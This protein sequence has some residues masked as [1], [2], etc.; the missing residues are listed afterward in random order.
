MIKKFY[1]STFILVFLLSTTGLPLTLHLCAMQKSATLET[2]E[3]C[4]A[5]P[6]KVKTC[7]SSKADESTVFLSKAADN[8]CLTQLVDKKVKDEFYP[9][10]ELKSSFFTPLLLVIS[11]NDITDL[12][13]TASFVSDSPPIP[14]GSGRLFLD[15]SILLI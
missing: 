14:P 7:C 10:T 11:S 6:E 4:S 9:K 13:N 12:R 5:K 1:I 15:I 8:C 3:M 2:C